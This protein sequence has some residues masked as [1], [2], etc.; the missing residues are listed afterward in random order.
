M[1]AEERVRRE[2]VECELVF[3][4]ERGL[5]SASEVSRANDFRGS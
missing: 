3:G 5:S 4:G 2:A 1:R